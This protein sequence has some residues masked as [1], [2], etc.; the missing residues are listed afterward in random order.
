MN[1]HIAFHFID[2]ETGS[3]LILPKD[4]K[5]ILAELYFISK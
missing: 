1:V 5:S 3:N 2:P 4:A